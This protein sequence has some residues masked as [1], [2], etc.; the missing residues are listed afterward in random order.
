MYRMKWSYPPE[1][2]IADKGFVCAECAELQPEGTCFIWSALL[3]IEHTIDGEQQYV[4]FQLCE[5]CAHPRRKTR[6]RIGWTVCVRCGTQY[7]GMPAGSRCGDLSTIPVKY[8]N[9]IPSGCAGTLIPLEEY[10]ER[11]SLRWMKANF[12]KEYEDYK[13]R[14]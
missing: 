4:R 10:R 6:K 3:P 12:D 5:L 14:S 2:G 7:D 13:S 1:D 9:R 11:V 8:W